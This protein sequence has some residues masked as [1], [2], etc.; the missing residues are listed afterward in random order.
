MRLKLEPKKILIVLKPLS[1]GAGFTVVEVMIAAAT[2]MVIL[3]GL[4][5][6][7]A[8]MSGAA[9]KTAMASSSATF[10]QELSEALKSGQACTDAL[11]GQTL[12]T[13]GGGGTSVKLNNMMIDGQM[14]GQMKD[15]T[16]VEG[17][18]DVNNGVFIDTM[19]MNILKVAGVPNNKLGTDVLTMAGTMTYYPATIHVQTKRVVKG[20]SQLGVPVDLP[21][22]V[23]VDGSDVIQKCNTDSS[24]AKVCS[25]SGGTWD[26]NAATAA[27]DRCKPKTTCQFGGSYSELST[28][29]QSNPSAYV[30]PITNGYNCPSG[31]QAVRSGTVAAAVRTSKYGIG[32]NYYGVF[33][34]TKCGVDLGA[35]AAITTGIVPVDDSNLAADLVV[36]NLDSSTAQASAAGA[37]TPAPVASPTPAPTAVPTCTLCGGGGGCFIAGTL[38]TMG[39]GAKK[40]IED[41][42]VGDQV[43]SYNE[44]ISSRYV[45]TVTQTLHHPTSPQFL[46]DVYLEDGKNFVANGVHWVY[47]IE[48]EKYLSMKEIYTVFKEHK[49]VTV[50]D[51]TGSHQ[52][53]AAIRYYESNEKVY[54][55]HVTGVMESADYLDQGIGHNYF[56]GGT[57]VHNLLPLSAK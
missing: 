27:V 38:V 31:F 11:V 8:A 52:R 30:N 9:Q 7:V 19:T 10:E 23:I 44:R 45:S 47:V 12:K 50:I 17:A 3:G 16:Q 37:S 18:P 4:M 49:S 2:S 33:T 15:G 34:C 53:I 43:L 57:L 13:N 42:K 46:Y 56:A 14:I 41:V 25:E 32:N 20:V 24:E 1:S 21:I 5:S 22:K 39:D 29:G 36:T 28:N 40:A 26:T 6:G 48:A 51:D 55:L 35:P 54:N